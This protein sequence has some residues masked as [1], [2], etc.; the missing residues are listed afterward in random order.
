MSTISLPNEKQIR[1]FFVANAVASETSISTFI[2]GAS[3]GEVQIFGEKGTTADTSGDFYL[4]KKNQKGSVSVSDKITPSDITYTAGTTPRSK[5]GKV[6]TFTLASNPTVGKSYTLVG[7]LNYANSEENF[8]T[9]WANTV[10]VTGDTKLSLLGRLAKQMADQLNK[11][12]NT[13]STAS[14][15]DSVA[16]VQ[17]SGSVELATGAAGS[18]DSVT[19]NGVELLAAAVPFNTS[20]A[21][22]ASDLADAINA[23][24][25]VPNYTASVAGAVVTI[26]SVVP[27][28]TPNG[29]VVD[30]TL[31]TMTS[32]D[33]NLSGGTETLNAKKNKYFLVSAAD[34]SLTISEK[35]W[36]LDDFKVGLKSYDQILWNFEMVETNSSELSNVTKSETPQ[37]FAKGQGYQVLELERYLVGHRAEYDLK[38]RTLEFD[39]TYDAAVGST[40]YMIDIK[41]FDTSINDPKKADKMLTIVSTSAS[42]INT[43]GNAIEARGG[44]TWVDLS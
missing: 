1:H 20:L 10:A 34:D 18:V 12:I 44:K 29:Y 36:I 13:T 23:N 5:V 26:T 22:T 27:G 15:T 33:T 16:G 39:R 35:D 28:T 2:S 19:V 41:Y 30:A 3:I 21:Q 25:T 38:D 11:S 24:V 17:A 43:I 32:N 37:V 9:F 14:G 42:V 8:I 4:A 6:Q 7:K 31:T 40:Y